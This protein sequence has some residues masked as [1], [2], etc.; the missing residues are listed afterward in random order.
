MLKG[1]ACFMFSAEKYMWFRRTYIHVIMQMVNYYEK[2]LNT[3]HKGA[4][5]MLVMFYSLIWV[6]VLHSWVHI[7]INHWAIH[8]W[9]MYLLCELK[10]TKKKKKMNALGSKCYTK[11]VYT[12]LLCVWRKEYSH[13]WMCSHLPVLSKK[14]C[15]ATHLGRASGRCAEGF[16]S[17]SSP[18]WTGPGWAGS[19]AQYC[20]QESEAET[21]GGVHV[22]SRSILL[23]TL[24]G[25]P[26]QRISRARRIRK[27]RR[28]VNKRKISF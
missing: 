9:F 14:D 7:I 17:G 15:W 4:P 23:A 10:K 6:V 24:K 1:L 27:S 18:H 16:Q 21:A 22:E 5:E 12:K 13:N 19:A 8:L 20:L 11:P 25:W 28:K 26:H 3:S 2:F